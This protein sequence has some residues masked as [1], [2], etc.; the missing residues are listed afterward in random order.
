MVRYLQLPPNL[1]LYV[2]KRRTSGLYLESTQRIWT[3]ESLI[4][5]TDILLKAIGKLNG[6]IENHYI[7]AATP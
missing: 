4:E 2:K 1:K 7:M 3:K 6:Y 5:G